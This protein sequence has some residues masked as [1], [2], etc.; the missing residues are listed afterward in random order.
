MSR[1]LVFLTTSPSATSRSTFV[2]TQVAAAAERAGVQPVLFSVGDLD[3]ADVLAGRT[4]AP[5]VARFLEAVSRAEGIVL[6][7]PV[8]KATY[9]G[10]LK[11]VVDLIGQDALVGRKAIG[12]A[13]TKLAAHG[14]E[15]AAAY[16][17]LFAF[18][19]LQRGE[20]LVVLDSEITI[21]GNGGSLSADAA[22][23][24]AV[25]SDAIVKL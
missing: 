22:G 23:R 2:A 10:A 16:R 8:Y 15:V 7:T 1:E 21:D 6:A 18:F 5:S 25:A 9:S 11:A 3:A 17:A 20:T 4:K 12:I 24:L 13:T 19:R 14:V